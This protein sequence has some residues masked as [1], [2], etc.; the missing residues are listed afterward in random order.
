MIGRGA[1]E[2]AEHQTS[3]SIKL[4]LRKRKCLPSQTQKGPKLLER[5]S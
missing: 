4:P 2:E 1:L 5:E 3:F